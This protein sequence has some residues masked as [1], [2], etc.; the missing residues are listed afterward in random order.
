M[1]DVVFLYVPMP[2]HGTADALSRALLEER[3]AACTNLVPG[4][5]SR[6]RWR[7]KIETSKEVLLLVK[8]D[9]AREPRTRARIEALH[10]YEVPCIATLAVESLNTS[11]LEWI[12]ENLSGSVPPEG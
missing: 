5:E 8:T 2:D 10:P 1:S 3:L 9:R 6:Y 4:V 11:Y 7:G 12:K